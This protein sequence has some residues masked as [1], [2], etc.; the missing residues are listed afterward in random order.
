MVRWLGRHAGHDRPASGARVSQPFA[1]IAGSGGVLGDALARQFSAAGY[2]AAGLRR[3]DCNLA[4]NAATSRAIAALQEKH[5]PAEVL[6]YNAGHL[7]VAPFLEQDPAAFDAC[8]HAGPA[9]AANCARALLPG[10]VQRARGVMIFTGATASLRGSAKFA[11]M[12]VGKFGLR[13]LTQ[14]LAREFQPQGVHIAHVLL[15]GMLRGSASVERFGNSGTQTME[16]DDVAAAYRWIAEQPRSAW[17]QELD[18]RTT[19]EKF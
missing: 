17:T 9:G 18:L 7:A 2:R 10:M 16:P 1:L 8:W 11:A 5:G 14:A 4:D 12:A 19:A 6:L 15:D 13:G 3:A